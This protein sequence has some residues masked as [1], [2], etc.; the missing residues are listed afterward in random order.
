MS[1]KKE[2]HT[3][4]Y[5]NK[6]A[7]KYIDNYFHKNFVCYN[8]PSTT[9]YLWFSDKLKLERVEIDSKGYTSFFV[10][11]FYEDNYMRVAKRASSIEFAVDINMPIDYFLTPENFEKKLKTYLTFL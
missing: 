8:H 10:E 1:S 2:K 4:P 3:C 5:C 9:V 7:A 11:I 6:E